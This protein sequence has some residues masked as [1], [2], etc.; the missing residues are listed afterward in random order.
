MGHQGNHY[1]VVF[2][3]AAIST[4]RLKIDPSKQLKL[5]ETQAELNDGKGKAAYEAASLIG[6]YQSEGNKLTICLEP[7]L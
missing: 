1:T 2:K 4:H 7:Q 3:R 6:I 5:I